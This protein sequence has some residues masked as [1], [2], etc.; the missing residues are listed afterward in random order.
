MG[1]PRWIERTLDKGGTD[2][3]GFKLVVGDLTQADD[4][5]VILSWL[6]HSLQDI[7]DAN[8]DVTFDLISDV[9]CSGPGPGQQSRDW[10]AIITIE[11][12]T[13]AGPRYDNGAAWR[14]FT[15]CRQ[16]RVNRHSA[17]RDSSTIAPDGFPWRSVWFLTER[18]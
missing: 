11:R 13:R 3:S 4:E 12:D 9:R 14:A 7:G 15:A 16:W 18:R 8:S 17:S 2:F 1:E 5:F 10:K 6:W